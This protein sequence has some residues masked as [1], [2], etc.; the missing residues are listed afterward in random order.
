M[1]CNI[2]QLSDRIALW[3]R[4]E[5]HDG[6]GIC[7]LSDLS[8][9]KL[10]VLSLRRSW[11]LLLR[12]SSQ[13]CHEGR[14]RWLCL[15]LGRTWSS[16]RGGPRRHHSRASITRQWVV[17]SGRFSLLRL[18]LWAL[19]FSKSADLKRCS[20]IDGKVDP[21][22]LA[23]K[24]ELRLVHIDWVPWRPLAGIDERWIGLSLLCL[25][26]PQ[27]LCKSLSLRRRTAGWEP[28]CSKRFEAVPRTS[29]VY[30]EFES[31]CCIV[32]RDLRQALYGH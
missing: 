14:Q 20:I 10:L 24:R 5:Q 19:R 6:R 12:D 29:I 32:S 15:C 4:A 21:S 31:D 7:L 11:L 25:V 23:L 22:R 18:A 9:L 17:R 30:E 3:S 13:R 26:I 27:P 28:R 16:S 1:Q 8:L 2:I